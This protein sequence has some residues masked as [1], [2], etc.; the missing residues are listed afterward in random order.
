M[1][2]RKRNVPGDDIPLVAGHALFVTATDPDEAGSGDASYSASILRLIRAS[3][4]FETV[5]VMRT[6][7]PA[8][9][10]ALLRQAIA[11]G[12]ALA[13]PLPIKFHTSVDLA[14][15]PAV[16][17]QSDNDG[18]SLVIFNHAELLGLVDGVPTGIPKVLI[19]HNLEHRLWAE[20]AAH[21]PQFP[22]WM[23]AFMERDARKF[24]PLETL[25]TGRVGSICSISRDEAVYFEALGPNMNVAAI[26]PTFD[27]APTAPRGTGSG[28]A[29]D[30]RVRLGFVGVHAWWPNAEAVAWLLQE[31][32]P[33]VSADAAEWHFFGSGSQNLARTAANVFGHGFVPS[34]DAVWQGIDVLVCPV[35]SGGGVTVKFCEAISRGKPVLATVRAAKGL[36]PITDPGVR[37]VE[38]AADWIAFLNGP[39]LRQFAATTPGPACRAQFTDDL[40][41]PTMMDFLHHALGA[42]AHDGTTA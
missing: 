5:T 13:S 39:F 9:R 23:R 3:G 36:A 42:K 10:P 33:H 34:I 22:G 8:M 27:H 20:R 38:S 16:R 14:R 31:V 29:G 24:L 32:A 28:E 7:G 6:R 11:M 30:R 35:F 17:Q 4:L 25:V 18:V 41:A 40:H 26:P 2:D 15:L 1:P 21:D 37:F 12:R 19:S